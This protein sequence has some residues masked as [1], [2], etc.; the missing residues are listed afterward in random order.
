LDLREIKVYME[1][2]E[3]MVNLEEWVPLDQE[4]TL[5]K[6]VEWECR[7]L[8][9]LLVQK[10]L[11]VPLANQDLEGSKACL[12]HLA[13]LE[14]LVKTEKLDFKDQWVHLVLLEEEANVVSLEKEVLKGPQDLL[15][16]VESLV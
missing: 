10:D 13:T 16:I 12:V 15:E 7:D 6:M 8:P 9:V 3:K 2:Q 1:H 14:R 4:E 5:V 11:E